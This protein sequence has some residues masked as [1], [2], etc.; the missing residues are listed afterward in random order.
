MSQD[1]D[2]I[3][4]EL[5]EGAGKGGGRETGLVVKRSQIPQG[6]AMLRALGF[7]GSAIGSQ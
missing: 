3:W 4:K 5:G 1:S 2:L 7:I 6:L